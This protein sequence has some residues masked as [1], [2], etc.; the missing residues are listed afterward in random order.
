MNDKFFDEKIKAAL[1]NL[2]APYDPASWAALEQRLNAPFSEEHPP[3]V[4]AVDKA[5]FHALERLEAPYQPAHW[6]MLAQRMTD[7]AR[8]RRRIWMSKLSEAAIF[9]LLL[10]N[11]DGFFGN[12]SP[13]APAP[14]RSP[15]PPNRPQAE[16]R[17]LN[18][19]PDAVRSERNAV[20][21]ATTAQHEV[22]GQMP[23]ED[24]LIDP[25]FDNQ[26]SNG[27]TVSYQ[28]ASEGQSNAGV[29]GAAEL[30]VPGQ[31]LSLLSFAMLPVLSN[32]ALDAP[33]RQFAAP[34]PILIKSPKKS[35]FY[36]STFATL[37]RNS[38][39]GEENYTHTSSGHGGGVGIGYRI[40]KW[41]VEAGLSHNRKRYQPKKE[42]EIHAGNTVDGFHG[43][44]NSLVEADMVSVPVKITRRVAQLGRMSAHFV[45]GATTNIALDKS[46]QYGTV[47]YPGGGPLT[48][49][50]APGQQPQL[51]QKGQ[52]LLENGSLN[53][54]VYASLDAGLRLEHPLGRRFVAFVE[55]AYR[56]S[57]GGKGIGPKPGKINTLSVQAGVMATL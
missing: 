37:D 38:F 24:F 29:L 42:V 50:A 28:I 52:G 8:L 1:D 32:Q 17:H 45:A 34:A 33:M 39:I 22:A 26:Q 21:F 44:F 56:H 46:Y 3:P 16:R 57:L 14:V 18:T 12:E 43:S 48:P 55:P 54:N 19:S 10:V 9:L 41:G 5:V 49:N 11:L 20:L 30:P 36:V 35:R 13:A 47:F 23:A 27:T 4:E 7:T 15:Q 31:R 6:K 40:G 25:I 53:G 51:R 2:E